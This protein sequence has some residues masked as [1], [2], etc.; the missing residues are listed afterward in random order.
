MVNLEFIKRRRIQ[1][2]LSIDEMADLLGYSN[3][4]N[5]YKY[6]VGTYK[7][8]AEILPLLASVLKTDIEN[9][10]CEEDAKT[11]TKGRKSTKQK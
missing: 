6:E 3:G 8:R 1:L 2:D 11:E 10:F 5:Y 9:F 4:S 7:F